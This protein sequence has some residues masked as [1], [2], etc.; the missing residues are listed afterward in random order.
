MRSWIGVVV[1]A[2]MFAGPARG[3]EKGAVAMPGNPGQ[4]CAMQETGQVGVSWNNV[5][6]AKL[7]RVGAEMDKRIDE[8]ISLAK[9]SGLAKI[10][11]Q[12]YSYN[13][14]PVSSG[15]PAGANV[16]YQYSGNVSLAV[17]PC[18]KASDL[19]SLLASKGYSANLNVNAY[20]QCQ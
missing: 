8:V 6:V 11:V 13:V 7:D 17:E 9:Q 4:T 10:E 19:M 2:V 3:W 1:V 15:L 20:R 14:Y 12:S 18:A 5:M 16:P